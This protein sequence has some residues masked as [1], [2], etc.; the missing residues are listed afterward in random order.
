[1]AT[2]Q[3]ADAGG[4]TV[5]FSNTPRAKDDAFYFSEDSTG[6]LIL[7]VLANDLGGA[8]KLL[9]SIDNSISASTTTKTP[10]PS[11][12]LIRDTTYSATNGNAGLAGTTDTSF[13]GARIW[14]ASD[15]TIHYNT[16]DINT[17]LQSLA[18]GQVLT[19]KL[20]YAIQL[21]NGT[22]SWA[23]TTIQFTGTNNQ[24]VIGAATLVGGVTEDAH[25]PT[26]TATG[27]VAFGDV[28]LTDVHLVSAVFKGTDYSGQLGSLNAVKTTDTTGTGS[29]GL[30][31]WTFSAA[32]SALDKLAAGQ[33]VD[34][35]YTVTLDDQHGGVVTRDV[36]ITIT[37]TNDA[38]VI[39]AATLVGAVTE[40]AP[41]R[42][43]QAP[44]PSA[45]SI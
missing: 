37:G 12:L 14:I 42:P 28:D 11:D 4:T 8:A 13:L 19:D 20:T 22:L 15:G 26:E 18:Q 34:E 38:P 44:S 41:P 29:G 35:T 21:G 10:A 43:P 33:V 23:T 31:T 5:S 24:P 1:M 32:D 17:L 36:V 7:N 25:I 40:E 30:I 16:A 9:Y 45:M 27:T 2:Q 6:V 3:I 39:G